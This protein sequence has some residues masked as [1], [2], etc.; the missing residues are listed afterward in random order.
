MVVNSFYPILINCKTTPTTSFYVIIHDSD[1]NSSFIRQSTNALEY[2]SFGMLS[3][4]QGFN[5]MVCSISASSHVMSF[6]LHYLA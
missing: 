4:D 3:S 2:D 6:K 5:S 1:H